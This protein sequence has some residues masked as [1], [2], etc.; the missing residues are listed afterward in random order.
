MRPRDARGHTLVEVTIA[1]TLGL[2]ILVAAVSVYRA[3]R[4]SYLAAGDRAR[5][6]DAA[7]VALDVIARQ[8]RI[9]GF[10]PLD[11]APPA[12]GAG[13]FG[14]T[15]GRPAGSVSTPA[16]TPL[17]GDSDGIEVRY[18]GDD[19]STWPTGDGQA[20]DCL[21]QGV[22]DARSGPLVVSRYFVRRSTSTGMPELYCEGSGRPGV[23][24]PLVEGVE[25]LRLRYRVRGAGFWVDASA[26]NAAQWPDVIAVDMC[27]QVRGAA[28]G[29]S[30]E[31]L[32][33]DGRIATA[34][35]ARS[36]FVARR[37][38]ALRNSGERT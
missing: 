29:R 18:V 9:A 5:R 26:L 13:L 1:M 24:Q 16:C 17:A 30:A 35:D 23:A 22:G 2:L 31:Y 36:R 7:G 32:D 25:R 27:V 4:V 12:G 34:R 33:C 37:Y 11:R 3:Q 28:A 20:T 21:G 19:V 8:I 14:C 38:V 10:A 15:G 6:L